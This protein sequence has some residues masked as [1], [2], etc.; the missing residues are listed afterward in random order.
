[1][2]SLNR[3]PRLRLPVV[4]PLWLCKEF[5]TDVQSSE[6]THTDWK[7]QKGTEASLS[8]WSCCPFHPFPWLMESGDT[9]RCWQVAEMVSPVIKDLKAAN[10]LSLPLLLPLEKDSKKKMCMFL[11]LATLPFM[12]GYSNCV[13]LGGSLQ[14]PKGKDKLGTNCYRLYSPNS[15]IVC[16]CVSPK[17]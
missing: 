11:H 16:R 6:A 10:A 14:S 5:A 2:S 3:F 13:K 12:C 7:M 8:M 9:W 1:M 15:I 17:C 4:L